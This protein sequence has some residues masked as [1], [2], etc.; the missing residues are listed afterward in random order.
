MHTKTIGMYFYLSFNELSKQIIWSSAKL[1]CIYVDTHFY[2]LYSLPT[3][4]IGVNNLYLFAFP[5]HQTFIHLC[6]D[7]L[8]YFPI[9]SIH[10]FFGRSLLPLS[11]ILF[12]AIDYLVSSLNTSKL[13]LWRH[14]C[15]RFKLFCAFLNAIRLIFLNALVDAI[16]SQTSSV[17]ISTGTIQTYIQIKY[18]K[19]VM[20]VIKSYLPYLY[21]KITI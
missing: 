4:V 13:L 3:H 18:R 15:Y 19:H 2:F 21:V 20:Y 16:V 10:F 11:L 12:H 6:L 17:T 9:T 5:C 1:T 7:V 8:T 14:I